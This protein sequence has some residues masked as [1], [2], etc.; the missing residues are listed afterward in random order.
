[1]TGLN[2]FVYGFSDDYGAIVINYTINMKKVFVLAVT[3]F[4]CN[5][6]NVNPLK[7]VSVNNQEYNLRQK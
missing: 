4:G 3:Y 6:L 2:A 1:M 7:C 5:V